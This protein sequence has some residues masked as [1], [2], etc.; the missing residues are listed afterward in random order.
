M[1][2]TPQSVTVNNKP[3]RAYPKMSSGSN[4]DTTKMGTSTNSLTLRS[5]ATLQSA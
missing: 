3:G 1:R 4:A 5:T 2:R